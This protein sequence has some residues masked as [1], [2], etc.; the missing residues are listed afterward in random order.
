VFLSDHFAFDLG[1]AADLRLGARRVGWVALDPGYVR[2][3]QAGFDRGFAPGARARTG[4]AEAIVLA[5]YFDV[6]VSNDPSTRFK[7]IYGPDKVFVRDPGQERLAPRVQHHASGGT[8][9]LVL[10]AE[11]RGDQAVANFGVFDQQQRLSDYAIS[12]ARPAT[13]EVLVY[14]LFET[15]S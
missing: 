14:L 15:S 11:A 10:Q 9:G 1:G 3:R 13:P 2:H 5:I 7:S 6:H 8:A 12:N 4:K